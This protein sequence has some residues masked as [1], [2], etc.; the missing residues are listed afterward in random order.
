MGH[1]LQKQ[2]KGATMM[3]MTMTLTFF[4]KYLRPQMTMT[5]MHEPQPQHPNPTISHPPRSQITRASQS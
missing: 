1:K 5:T 2:R 4:M 3:M